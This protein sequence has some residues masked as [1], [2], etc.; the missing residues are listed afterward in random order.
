ML[1][2]SKRLLASQ[3]DLSDPLGLLVE[4]L[5]ASIELVAL[6]DND[7]AWSSWQDRDAAVTSF[8][9][10]LPSRAK[11]ASRRACRFQ[12]CSP[13]QARCRNSA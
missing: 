5:E 7:F 3:S 12:I 8:V 4:V 1:E 13:R 9:A 11:A 2:T 10:Y 6:D